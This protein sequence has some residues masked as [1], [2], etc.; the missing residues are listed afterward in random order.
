[1]LRS[2]VPNSLRPARSRTRRRDPGP[3][4]PIAWAALA[5]LPVTALAA[6][7]SASPSTS[8]V[9][10]DGSAVVLGRTESAKVLVRVD[11]QPAADASPL[12]LSVNVGSFSEPDRVAPGQYRALYVPPRTRFPQM[13]LV[14]VWRETGPEAR[15]DFVRFPLSG[16]TRLTVKAPPGSAVS[17]KVGPDA[18]GPVAASARGKAILPIVAPPGVRQATVTI[19]GESGP[20]L[21]EVALEVPPYNR[22]IAAVVPAT[23]PAD[24][25]TPV[26]L[27]VFYDVGG[28]EVKADRVHVTASEGQATLV[29]ASQGRYSYRYLPVPG[30]SASEVRFHVAVDGDPAAR[31]GAKVALV[32]PPPKAASVQAAPAQVKPEPRAT[33]SQVKARFFPSPIVADG[34]SWATMAIELRDEAGKPVEGAQLVLVASAGAVEKLVDRGRGRYEAGYC[35]PDGL[36]ATVRLTDPGS[37]FERAVPVPLR[38]N[39]GRFLMGPRVGYSRTLGDASGV[40]LG[41]DSWI[42]VRLG[43]ATFGLGFSLS[44]GDAS[45]TVTDG[46]GT[47]RSSSSADFYP[48]AAR[49]GYELWAGERLSFT[50]GA[51]AAAALAR[52]SSSLGSA[53]VGLGVGPLGFA[54]AAYAI[55]PGQLFAEGSASWV[56]IATPDYRLEAGGLALEAGYRLRI[57]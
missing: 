13:A 52:F 42:P 4:R 26:R 28:A 40:R 32:A 39:P 23:A 54:S 9:S 14:A 11:E 45:L 47:L 19:S 7:I 33:P 27:E 35:A 31:A 48:F 29:E 30:S 18:F 50:A 2:C 20:V 22:L 38:V 34:E 21:R 41:V 36:E 16:T 24:G 1:M 15:V 56:P 25:K 10:I 53:A 37:G 6:S 51:G 57:F 5:L 43:R 12:R 44:H 46:V 17:A 8:S 3:G 55:G 49:V